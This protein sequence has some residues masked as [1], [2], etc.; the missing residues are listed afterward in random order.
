MKKYWEI[1]FLCVPV[2]LILFAISGGGIGDASWIGMKVDTLDN[3]KAAQMGVPANAGHVVVVAVNDPA[4]KS[5]V[6]VGDLVVG[7]NS[8][9]IQSV[10]DFLR[11]AQ[12]VMTTRGPDGRLPDVVLTLNRLGHSLVVTVPSEW[13]ETSI[14][15]L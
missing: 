2:L 8:R 6:I 12:S 13:I 14:R 10:E 9:K 7:I 1:S 11:S 4:L 3:A 15:Q 5:G